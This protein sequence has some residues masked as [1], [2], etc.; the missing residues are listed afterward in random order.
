MKYVLAVTVMVACVLLPAQ[1]AASMAFKQMAV[2]NQFAFG[3]VGYSGATSKGEIAFRAI[4]RQPRAR[5]LADFEK[6]YATGNA[7]A[8]AYAL[9]GIRDLAPMRFAALQRS[10]ASSDITVEVMSGCI[11]DH[12]NLRKLAADLAA[13]KYDAI[14]QARG[15]R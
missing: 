14:M 8:K 12:E 5:A 6:L 2:V 1:D 4:L 15:L 13:G 9:A 3:G 10:L 11:A 7:Q